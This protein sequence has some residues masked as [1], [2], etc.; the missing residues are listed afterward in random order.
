MPS[1]EESV[2]TKLKRIAE[3]ARKDPHCRFT[4]L[5]HLMNHDLLWE[6][7]W[8]LKK[9]KA[10]G[11]D[12]V[13]KDLYAENLMANLNDLVERLHRMAYIPQPVLRVNIP[14]PGSDKMRPL[15]I[16]TLEDKLVQSGLSKILQAIY[17]QDFIEDSYG[18]RPKRGCHDALRVLGQTIERRGTQYIVEADIR[19]FF[20]N[21][22]QTQLMKFLAHRIADKR[23]IR[24]IK[25]ILKSGIQEEGVFRA[26]DRGTPQGG[27]ISPLL[28][29]LYLHY[30]LDLW[31]ER[32][33]RK[34]CTGTSRFIRYADDFVVCFKQEADARRF[35]IEMEDRLNQFGLEIAPEKT[36]ILEFGPM[37]QPRAKQRGE[38]AET[39]DFLGFTHF[40]TTSRNGKMFCVGR[41]SI[42]KR[43]TAKLNFF[44]EWL[45][46]SRTQPTAAIMETAANKL[47]GHYAY[48]GVTGNS[49]SI[50][51]YYYEVERLLFKW[52]GRRGKR[53]SLNYEKFK[54]L[55][56]RFP[57][58][59]PRI[60][61]NLW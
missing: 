41:K 4:S 8:E 15:G 48:Y 9:C 20:D 2:A 37:A 44:K 3:K 33:F 7:F 61:V 53:G 28:A 23:I 54:L 19:G 26:S 16:P 1:N 51:N 32:V 60:L 10:S 43:I 25:R 5:F 57:L 14:K 49:K 52:L 24:Y 18:F 36:K 38:K 11:I 34:S 13:T 35:R 21:V 30:T 45:R 46:A 59:Y 50:R 27:V 6:C 56:Q 47:R 39:F 55:L 58:P 31:F 40:C 17:E 42:S 12:Q 22:D 29:N